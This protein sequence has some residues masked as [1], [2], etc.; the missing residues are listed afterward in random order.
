MIDGKTASEIFDSIRQHVTTGAL[1]PGETLPPVRELA[2]ELNVN[3]N[4]VAAAYKRLVTSGL[5]LSQG[6]NGTVIK[7]TPSPLALEGSSPDTPLTD[8]SGGNP[9]PQRLP[10]LSSYFSTIN[11]SP[12]LYGDAAV[13]PALHAWAKQWM[14]DAVPDEGEIDITSGAIDAI[15]RLLCAHLLPGDSVAVEDPCFLSSISMLR[16]AG[17]SAIPV[18]VDSEGMQPEMLEQALKNGARAVILTPRAHNPTGCSL[19]ASRAAALQNIVAKYPQALVIIDDHFALLSSSPWH[20]V[21]APETLHWSVVRSM[22]KTLGPDLRLAIVASDPATSARLRLRLNSGSQWVSHLLQ[23]LV[24]AC[25]SDKNY[26]RTLAQTRQFYASQQQKLAC[27]LQRTGLTHAPGDGLNAWLPL[28]R[29]SQGIAFMLA[30]AG[31]LVREGEAFGVNAPAHGLRITLSTLG[32]GDIN[33]LAAD[34]HQAL[35]R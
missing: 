29:H 11:K 27:A 20:P 25:L 32:D 8:L 14:Q 9:D 28:K 30:K 15:E 35:K 3:R 22:S 4:T 26:Q 21:I 18:G 5:A 31:W 1:A 10:D 6:R 23:D 7:G 17:F 33:K 13:S 12:R 19:S 16:Y 2:S 24:H 34:I